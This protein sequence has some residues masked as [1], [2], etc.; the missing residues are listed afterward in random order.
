MTGALL[1]SGCSTSVPVRPRIELPAQPGSSIRLVIYRPQTLVGMWG[2]PTILVNGQ[3]MGIRGSPTNANFL[4]PGSVFVVDA[5]ASL[6]RVGW[7]QTGKTEPDA[8]EIVFRD[9][10]G[11]TR[12]LRWTLKPTYGYLQEVEA[13][14]ARDEIGP[15]RFTG[16][17]DLVNPRPIQ[18]GP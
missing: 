4:A 17:M 6:A 1:L 8:Q 15:L 18:P 7:I 5:P 10:P 3:P 9:L 12:H 11:A 13:G 14:S 2:K 16:Y